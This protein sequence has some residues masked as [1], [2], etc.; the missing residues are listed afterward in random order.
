MI[1]YLLYL[2]GQQFPLSWLF[3]PLSRPQIPG[4]IAVFEQ[5][6]FQLEVFQ[7]TA[8]SQENAVEFWTYWVLCKILTQKIMKQFMTVILKLKG[9]SRE[10][11]VN[12][13]PSIVKFFPRIVNYFPQIVKYFILFLTRR[14]YI[15]TLRIF[16]DLSSLYRENNIIFYSILFPYTVSSFSIVRIIKKL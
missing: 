7:L 13:F 5:K 9:F 6:Q 8:I 15:R 2:F 14:V 3:N 10:N 16:R 4:E 1:N 11:T 12:H